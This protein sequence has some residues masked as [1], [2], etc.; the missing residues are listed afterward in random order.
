LL[1][2]HDR[3]K[4]RSGQVGTDRTLTGRVDPTD[5]IPGEAWMRFTSGLEAHP[6][7]DADLALP[8]A[9]HLGAGDLGVYRSG[10]LEEGIAE[11]GVEGGG[12]W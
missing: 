12:A 11:T 1:V 10:Q 8:R 3:G 7:A 9:C 6:I 2:E 4:E 5:E